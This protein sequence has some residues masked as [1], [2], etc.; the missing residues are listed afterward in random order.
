[1]DIIESESLVFAL[2]TLL[3]LS[4]E[5]VSGMQRKIKLALPSS[6]VSHLLYTSPS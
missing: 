3:S 2:K 5:N 1:M 4:L 6:E